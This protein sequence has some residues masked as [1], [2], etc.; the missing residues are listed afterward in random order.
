MVSSQCNMMKVLFL[1]FVSFAIAESF[2]A[3][4]NDPEGYIRKGINGRY[5]YLPATAASSRTEDT[6]EIP[7]SVVVD[8]EDHLYPSGTNETSVEPSTQQDFSLRNRKEPKTKTRSQYRIGYSSMTG[9]TRG[10][11]AGRANFGK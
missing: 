11:A 3:N 8:Y 4:E 1:L 6:T 10:G 7:D 5:S 2:G 9:G